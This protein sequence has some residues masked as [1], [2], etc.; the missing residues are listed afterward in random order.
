LTVFTDATSDQTRQA[1]TMDWLWGLLGLGGLGLLAWLGFK[2]E[3]HWVSKDGQRMLC[4]GQYM[5]HLGM[6]S[7]RWRET[8][9]FIDDE[10][11]AMVD[12]KKMLRHNASV[13]TV[14]AESPDPPPRRAIFLLRGRTDDG[15][16]A[17][18]ALKLPAKSKGNDTLRQAIARRVS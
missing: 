9:V 7:G 11:N 4:S 1:V 6:P 8:R 13:W 18:L 17:M 2:I 14:T 5:N 12:Q 3:P 16:S 10:G 15:Q